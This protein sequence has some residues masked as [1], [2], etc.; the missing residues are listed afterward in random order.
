MPWFRRCWFHDRY[1][2]HLDEAALSDLDVHKVLG[3]EFD[4]DS[5]GYIARNIND[6]I[7]YTTVYW[8]PTQGA[9]C[10]GHWRFSYGGNHS[11][12][13]SFGPALIP[14]EFDQTR[15]RQVVSS[16]LG[17]DIR[18]Q[19]DRLREISGLGYLEDFH[20]NRIGRLHFC[21]RSRACIAAI[22]HVRQPL[23][24]RLQDLPPLCN[25]RFQHSFVGT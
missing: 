15:I 12:R 25:I 14:A 5:E 8:S 1:D 19:E 13:P 11:Q 18:T 4:P 20:R 22:F 6:A 21:F 10:S 2:H 23:I 24:R 3:V 17:C 9:I 16:K 7:R